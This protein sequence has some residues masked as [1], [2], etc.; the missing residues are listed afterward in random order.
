MIKFI[1]KKGN[2]LGFD[3]G[4]P[5]PSVYASQRGFPDGWRVEEITKADLEALKRPITSQW[6][7]GPSGSAEK[8]DQGWEFLH[9]MFESLL[10]ILPE[11][12]ATALQTKTLGRLRDKTFLNRR[13][14]I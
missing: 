12:Q 10:E 14:K 4:D 2:L 6:E 13:K 7:R 3:C 5:D 9:A 8:A 1:D 11:P